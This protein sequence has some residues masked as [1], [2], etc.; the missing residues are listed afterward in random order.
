[1]KPFTTAATCAQSYTV[2][3]GDTCNAIGAKFGIS[4]AAIINANSN[5]NAGCTNLQIG[6]VLCIPGTTPACASKYTVV[7]GDTCNSIGAKFGVT[8]AA[9][10]S[11]NSNNVNSG[12]TNL[13]IGEILCIPG[14]PSQTP[15]AVPTTMPAPVS[16]RPVS[17]PSLAP[18]NVCS[19][20][21]TVV[22]GDTCNAI[23]LKFGVSAASIIQANPSINAQC[24]NLQ[25]GAILCIPGISFA[26][27]IQPVALPP[28]TTPTV[29]CSAKYTVVSGD[30][31]NAI[32]LKFGVSAAA[33]I[34]A[35][36]SIN[37]QCTNLQIGAVLCIPFSTSAPSIKPVASPPTV[38]CSK[39]YTVVSGDTCNGIGLKFG[40]SAGSIIQ[41]NPSINAQC[42]NLQ[43]GAVLCIP[44]GSITN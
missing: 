42:T 25:L 21:Y 24:T 27:S 4:G 37:A 31:C 32:G 41:A 28:P 11:A 15:V 35:N 10:I 36:P 2:V 12:C 16:S 34:Q 44:I 5:I 22:S 13:N 20:K 23:G 29:T 39:K 7:Q 1:M 8:A 19:V 18:A 6:E 9:I 38:T 43:I 40:V 33:I 17:A 14:A 30:T 26:P 3:Q